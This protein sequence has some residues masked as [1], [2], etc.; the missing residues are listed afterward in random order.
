MKSRAN[1]VRHFI[2]P[3][4]EMAKRVGQV[5]AH[6][7]PV[8][9]EVEVFRC[10][11]LLLGYHGERVIVGPQ[12]SGCL[13][14]VNDPRQHQPLRHLC[15]R[16]AT[17][18]Q[19]IHYDPVLHPAVIFDLLDEG[20]LAHRAR[21]ESARQP[22]LVLHDG[23]A[24][25]HIAADLFFRRFTEVVKAGVVA[26]ALQQVQGRRIFP[27]VCPLHPSRGKCRK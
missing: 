15:T 14:H 8:L 13:Q 6:H 2:Q 7:L 1:A 21:A 22:L 26:R 20:H 18:A 25:L 24:L 3:H 12:S 19:H 27:E 9:H 4:R 16:I 5:R 10:P 11:S 23:K 17:A